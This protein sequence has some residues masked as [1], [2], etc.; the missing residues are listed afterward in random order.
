MGGAMTVC[1]MPFIREEEKPRHFHVSIH[2]PGRQGKKDDVV[3]HKKIYRKITRN[4]G[5]VVLFV[6]FQNVI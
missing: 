4:S 6:G 1:C 3:Q 5:R 2:A